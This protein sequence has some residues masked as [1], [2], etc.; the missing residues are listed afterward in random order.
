MPGTSYQ[1]QASNETAS[2]RF[3]LRGGF[4]GWWFSVYRVVRGF[5]GKREEAHD[6]MGTM[7]LR[8]PASFGYTA[9]ECESMGKLTASSPMIGSGRL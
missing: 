3:A 2:L 4:P 9:Q 8:L 5:A 6:E 1:R 7:C